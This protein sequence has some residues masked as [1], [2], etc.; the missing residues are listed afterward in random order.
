VDVKVAFVGGRSKGATPEFEQ[1]RA[2]AQKAGVPWRAVEA[3]ALA[4]FHQKK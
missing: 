3:A 4:A 1:C 2:A